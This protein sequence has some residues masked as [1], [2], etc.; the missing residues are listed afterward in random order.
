MEPYSQPSEK[1]LKKSEFTVTNIAPEFRNE[2]EMAAQKQKITEN[3]YRIF[4]KYTNI[5]NKE[6]ENN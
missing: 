1:T 3:L 4:V 5:S 2:D 6:H